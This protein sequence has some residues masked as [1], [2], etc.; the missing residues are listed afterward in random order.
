MSLSNEGVITVGATSLN[1]LTPRDNVRLDFTL[2]NT[3]AALVISLRRQQMPA[4]AGQG[5]VL[6]PGESW[7]EG[8]DRDMPCYQGS[9]QA[10]STGAGATL[11]YSERVIY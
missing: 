1:V 4:I 6:R 9:V 3:S 11:A 5:I 10:I 7:T 2:T 8:S